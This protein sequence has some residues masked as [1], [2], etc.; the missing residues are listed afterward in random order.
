VIGS[1]VMICL[2]ASEAIAA[3][4]VSSSEAFSNLP[5]RPMVNLSSLNFPSG[6]ADVAFTGSSPQMTSTI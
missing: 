2:N 3:A 6:I 5:I 4:L 1:P